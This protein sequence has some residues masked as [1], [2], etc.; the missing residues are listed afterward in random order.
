LSDVCILPYNACVA[1]HSI[2]ASR[3]EVIDDDVA[4]IL[5]TK[6][7]AERVAMIVD[8]DRVM[9]LRM[10]ATLRTWHPDWSSDQIHR[11][12]ARRMTRETG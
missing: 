12:I 4:D 9:R 8:A 11:E 10:E 6:S 1:K 2:D 3:I 7:P 5:R